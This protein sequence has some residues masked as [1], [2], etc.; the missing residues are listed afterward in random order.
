LTPYAQLVSQ[1]VDRLRAA[2]G[3]VDPPVVPVFAEWE[4][5]DETLPGSGSDLTAQVETAL[6]RAGI[7]VIVYVEGVSLTEQNADLVEV[8]VQV[9]ENIVN[10]RHETGTQKASINVTHA[11]RSALENWQNADHKEWTPLLFAG[12]STLS[13][14]PI[15]IREARFTTSTLMSTAY[16]SQS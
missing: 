15:M 5:P 13:K 1:I 3:I 8:R 6:A 2:E 9:V 10:N 12:I 11:C 16:T 4:E 14:G 7:A